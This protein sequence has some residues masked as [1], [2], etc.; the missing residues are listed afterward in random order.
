MKDQKHSLESLRDQKQ[1][2]IV[3]QPQKETL[4]GLVP[5]FHFAPVDYSGNNL[6]AFE[7][8]TARHL[9]ACS[10]FWDSGLIDQLTQF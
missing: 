7:E 10:S 3:A 8:K 4:S 5:S 6:L 2:R 1:T 9:K